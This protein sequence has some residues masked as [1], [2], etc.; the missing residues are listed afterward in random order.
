MPTS[1]LYWGSVAIPQATLHLGNRPRPGQKRKPEEKGR[2]NTDAYA[3]DDYNSGKIANWHPSNVW[4]LY[5]W[6]LCCWAYCTAFAVLAA[7]H[8]REKHR[9]TKLYLPQEAFNFTFTNLSGRKLQGQIEKLDHGI[10]A[11][12]QPIKQQ[13]GKRGTKLDMTFPG[14]KLEKC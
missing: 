4:C 6:A 8:S 12:L 10:S 9:V 1:C 11:K 2:C 5:S 3:P 7:A 13:L 14:T